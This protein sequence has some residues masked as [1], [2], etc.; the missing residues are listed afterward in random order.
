M[1]SNIYFIQSLKE[2]FTAKRLFEDIKLFNIQRNNITSIEF[3]DVSNKNDFYTELTR[4]E[5]AINSQS[6]II[7][8]I[9]AHSSETIFEFSNNETVE[10]KEIQ[11]YF[12]KINLQCLNKLH[13]IL[14]SC[15]G[16][17]LSASN[18]DLKNKIPYK[19]LTAT[20]REIFPGVLEK[21][22]ISFYKEILTTQNIYQAYLNLEKSLPNVQLKIKDTETILKHFFEISIYPI[23]EI[24]NP[25]LLNDLMY[26]LLGIKLNYKDISQKKLVYKEV[27]EKHLKEFLIQQ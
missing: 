19:T 1:I 6:E 10:W 18:F 21:E 2:N 13:V 16:M 7:I 12:R 27:L 9:E 14:G 17:Y 24:G 23:I 3:K 11:N 15:Y 8:H 5:N 22:N 26:D 20:N 4:I 25:E